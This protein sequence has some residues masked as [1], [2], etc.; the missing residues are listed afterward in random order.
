MQGYG[1]VPLWTWHLKW[2]TRRTWETS[3]GRASKELKKQCVHSQ[4]H[5]RFSICAEKLETQ[6]NGWYLVSQ[7]IYGSS[8]ESSQQLTTLG[9]GAELFN[10]PQDKFRSWS[11]SGRNNWSTQQRVRLTWNYMWAP[12][13]TRLGRH[14]WLGRGSRSSDV[15]RRDYL[16]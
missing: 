11:W 7:S 6:L 16:V 8:T 12:T 3:T 14:S 4:K 13:G 1:V 2:S 10:V 15:L 9:S 5:L